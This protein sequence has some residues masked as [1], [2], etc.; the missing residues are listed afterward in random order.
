M[1]LKLDIN[2]LLAEYDNK[3][4]EL[5]KENLILKAQVKQLTK[6]IEEAPKE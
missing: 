1:E 4:A 5:Q 2:T 3:L 6:M